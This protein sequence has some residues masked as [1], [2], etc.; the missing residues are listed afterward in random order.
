VSLKVFNVALTTLG[1]QARD[2]L[3]AAYA[4]ASGGLGND[5]DDSDDEV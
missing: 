2:A 1:S 4:S 5:D 3:A